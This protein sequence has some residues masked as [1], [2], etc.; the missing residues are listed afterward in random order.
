MQS[1]R[2]SAMSTAKSHAQGVTVYH[3][4]TYLPQGE[5]IVPVHSARPATLELIESLSAVPLPGTARIAD[6]SE[7]SDLGFFRGP[8][9]A[10]RGFHAG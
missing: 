10:E 7:I 3:Y 9:Q 8:S 5:K 1:N 6:P 2:E 4:Y